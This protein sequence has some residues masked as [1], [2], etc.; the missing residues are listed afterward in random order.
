MTAALGDSSFLSMSN[1]VLQENDYTILSP[2]LLIC[3]QS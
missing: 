2:V 1:H 3:S